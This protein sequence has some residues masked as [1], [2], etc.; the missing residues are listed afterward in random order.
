MAYTTSQT[1]TYVNDSLVTNT[2]NMTSLSA[3]ISGTD[4]GATLLV[5]GSND[6]STWN[7]LNTI[8]TASTVAVAF[9]TYPIVRARISVQGS[10]S[11]LAAFTATIANAGTVV[12]NP[13]SDTALTPTV[14]A[15]AYTAGNVVGG[16]LTFT[17][18]FGQSLRGTLTDILVKSKSVQ[19]TTYKLY[20]F[21]QQPSASTWT[22]KA[23]PA[24]NAA[25][26]PYLLG[27]YTSGAADSGLGTETSN[28]LNNIASNIRSN[29]QNLYGILVCAATPTYAST[30]DVTVSVR[31]LQV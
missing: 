24:I 1:L 30:S 31:V 22:D 8:T 3:T 10:G 16:L 6:G 17:N 13:I 19:T 7:T 18:V 25:D 21:S 12:T 26:L 11:F 9:G 15:A 27:V 2:A 23:A 14:T 29:S 4:A 20:L 5:E 28:Q